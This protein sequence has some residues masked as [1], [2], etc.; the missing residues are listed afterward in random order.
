MNRIHTA[1]KLYTV[2]F[3]RTGGNRICK[4]SFL[5]L[6]SSNSACHL[7]PRAQH[8]SVLT[9]TYQAC[10]NGSLAVDAVFH[11]PVKE[12]FNSLFELRNPQEANGLSPTDCKPASRSRDID[13]S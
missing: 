6:S 11:T 13:M 2:L 5:G 3:T 8:H 10:H 7:E 4:Y 1:F 9:L 12:S